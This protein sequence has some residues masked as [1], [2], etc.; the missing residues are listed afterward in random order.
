[1]Y[2]YVLLLI[3]A[4]SFSQMCTRRCPAVE[5]RVWWDGVQMYH[6]GWCNCCGPE[7][8]PSPSAVSVL[9]STSAR[10]LQESLQNYTHNISIISSYLP[11]FVKWWLAR[12]LC[13]QSQSSFF[14]HWSNFLTAMI[15]TVKFE[16]AKMQVCF[17]TCIIIQTLYYRLQI[18]IASFLIFYFSSCFWC[19]T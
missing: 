2:N 17:F 3:A 12:Q 8:S 1:M 5:E 10:G 11:H 9:S 14:W 15:K 7:T 6:C 16:A 4:T 18:I 19:V 13:C